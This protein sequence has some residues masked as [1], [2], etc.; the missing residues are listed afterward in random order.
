MTESFLGRCL[1]QQKKVWE[2]MRMK[3][4]SLK[5]YR[6]FKLGLV[7]FWPL[8]AI[9]LVSLIFFYPVWLRGRIPLPLDALVGAHTPWVEVEWEGY[10]AGVPIKNLEITDAISQFYPW[11]SLVGEFWRNGK[12]PLWNFYM[13]NGTPFLATLHSSALYPLNALY[14]FLSDA[15]AWTSLVYLQILLSVIFM[16]LFLRENNLNKIPSIFGAVAFSFSGYMISW[17]EFATGGHAGLWLPFLFFIEKRVFERKKVIYFISIP[18]IFFFIFTAGVFQVPIYIVITYIL[19]SVYK[20]FHDNK[21][22]V[23]GLVYSVLALLLG[24]LIS[25][26]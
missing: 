1:F 18:L 14:L 10:P 25:S 21:H 4:L 23:R 5:Y 8:A 11:R 19:Y 12:Y 9:L 16:Y 2:F 13:F 24:I 3:D 15:N 6:L 17:L 7:K 20:Y 26:P 22:S